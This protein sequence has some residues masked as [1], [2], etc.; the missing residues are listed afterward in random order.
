MQLTQQIKLIGGTNVWH[1]SNYQQTG[2]TNAARQYEQEVHTEIQVAEAAGQTQAGMFHE[3]FRHWSN[4]EMEILNQVNSVAE[5]ALQGQRHI[6]IFEAF[7]EIQHRDEVHRHLQVSIEEDDRPHVE[8]LN[9]I[10]SQGQA[11]TTRPRNQLTQQGELSSAMIESTRA[12]ANTPSL[13]MASQRTKLN[14]VTV[15]FQTAIEQRDAA[16]KAA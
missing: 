2:C 5:H 16:A 11:E 10:L 14:G 12:Q 9:T 1:A 8:Q 4:Q 7:T 13:E 3:F 15:Q 6:S